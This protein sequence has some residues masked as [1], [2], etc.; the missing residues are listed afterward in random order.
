VTAGLPPEATIRPAA[1]ADVAAV[2]RL[3][4]ELA[5]Y[6]RAPESV[7]ATEELLRAALFGEPPSAF[8]HVAQVG[9]SV[10]GFALWFVNFSTWLG[11]PG[12][13]LEDLFVR[14][15]A[16]GHGLGR[17]LLS[18]LAGIAVERGYG[19]LDWAVLTWNAPA[20]GFYRSLGARPLDDWVGY[21]LA[22]AELRAV[23][24]GAPIRAAD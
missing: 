24:A 22:G 23:A 2:L 11:R 8:C 16:R 18:T 9:G 7:T 6:E 5:A 10:E 12:L 17:A 13:Y 15:G 4:R 14:P 20:I 1:P 19:R 21:R 3:I